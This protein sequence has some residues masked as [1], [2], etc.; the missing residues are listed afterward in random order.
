VNCNHEVENR[1]RR[2]EYI[3]VL[4]LLSCENW[5][6]I[7]WPIPLDVSHNIPLMLCGN[8]TSHKDG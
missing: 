6:D 1:R 3:S 4:L 2:P 5:D 8:G 7:P